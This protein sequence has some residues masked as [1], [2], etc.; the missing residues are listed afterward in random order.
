MLD[1]FEALVRRSISREQLPA[2]IL[3]FVAA[4]RST[5]DHPALVQSLDEPPVMGQ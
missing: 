1:I 2:R 3:D 5:I 4:H